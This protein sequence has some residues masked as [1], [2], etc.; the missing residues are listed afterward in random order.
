[1]GELRIGSRPSRRKNSSGLGD[2]R[3]I[4][5]S[6]GWTQTRYILPGWYGVGQA[7]SAYLD[8]GGSLSL[9]REMAAE[10]P[11]FQ[12]LMEKVE[13]TLA[14]A[15]LGI[16]ARYVRALD[17]SPVGIR[18]HGH[19]QS[20]YDETVARVLEIMQEKTLLENNPVLQRS[21]QVRNPYVDPMSLLQ[22][23]LLKKKRAGA[24]DEGLQR[25]LLLTISGVVAGMRNTG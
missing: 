6:F 20:A 9:L 13:M 8:A 7:L 14:K 3:A 21:I 12:A 2:L 25:A 24:Q 23:A 5:W 16:A 15:D 4:P 22:V 10:W 17:P 11:F 18:I 1:L 19:L